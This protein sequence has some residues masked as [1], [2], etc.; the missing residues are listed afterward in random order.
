MSLVSLNLEPHSG[1]LP[2]CKELNYHVIH[3]RGI[4]VV[5]PL[6]SN[7]GQTFI[8]IFLKILKRFQVNKSRHMLFLSFENTFII[9]FSSIQCRTVWWDI[10]G[11]FTRRRHHSEFLIHNII[12]VPYCTKQNEIIIIIWKYSLSLL[13]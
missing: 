3:L 9:K 4:L 12:I 10:G 7:N 5:K 1:V 13:E 8:S 2:V 11:H 6:I